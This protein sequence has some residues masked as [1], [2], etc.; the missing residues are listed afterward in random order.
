MIYCCFSHWCGG[1][2]N[3]NKS[4]EEGKDVKETVGDDKR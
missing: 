2:K 4:D 3:S 1:E